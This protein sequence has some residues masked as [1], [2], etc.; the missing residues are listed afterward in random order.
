MNAAANSDTIDLRV[1]FNKVK[2]NWYWFMIC[3]MVFGAL[4][5][6]YIKTTPKT[7]L[8]SST[9]LLSEQSKGFGAQRDEFL[10][11]QALLRGSSAIEDMIAILTSSKNITNALRALDF[12]VT[13]HETKNFLEVE[14]FDY[15]P[16]YVK[17]DSATLQAAAVPIK[18]KIDTANNTYE[19]N[20]EAE[21][22]SLY[23][24]RTQQMT[25]EFVLDFKVN[26]GPIKIGEPFKSPNLSFSIEFPEDRTYDSETE[27]HFIIHSLEGQARYFRGKLGV[28]PLSD[29]SNIVVLTTSGSIVTKEKAFIDKVMETYI[30]SESQKRKE[31]GLKTIGYIDELIGVAKDSLKEDEKAVREAITAG[32]SVFDAEA[33]SSFKMSEISRLQD[34]RAK[35]NAKLRYLKM[36]QS[37][38]NSSDDIINIAAPRSSGID[39]PG[40]N[41]QV[42]E[43]TKLNADLASKDGGLLNNPQV[44]A[45]KKRRRSL[46]QALSGT[47]SGLIQSTEFVIEDLSKR[48][49]SNQYQLNSLPKTFGQLEGVTREAKLSEDLYTY[50]QEKRAEAGIAIASDQVDK[51]VVDNAARVS[52]KP[53]SPDKKM[54]LGGALLL[55]LALPLGVILLRDLFDDTVGDLDELKRVSTVPVLTTIPNSKRKRITPDEPKSVLAEA[56]RT[57]R[58][59]LQYLNAK[60][61]TNIIG[62][63]SSTSGEGKSFCA[64]NL[65]TIM[66]MSGKRTVLVDCDMRRPR[67]L[68]YMKMTSE[69]GLSTYLIDECSIDDLTRS[70]DI[71][72]LDVIGAGPI[73]PNPLE[74]MES[75]RL[76]QLLDNLKDRYDRIVLDASPMGLVSEFVILMQH[77]D[78]TLYVVRENVTKKGMLDLLNENYQNEK[79]RNVNL[80][81]NDVKGAG[82]SGDQY[83]YYTK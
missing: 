11:G 24:I 83:G 80:I 15:P 82:A 76:K 5:V 10:K 64:I 40:L 26:S 9:M 77:L 69:A 43:L 12:G 51:A 61:N 71:A 2:S 55:G 75:P 46:R 28:E 35:E 73:P 74:L 21:N 60:V 33:A 22:V 1:I 65:A 8:V 17:V 62:L 20:A 53:I 29:E 37:E 23:N 59:N 72:G 14:K 4:A 19:V 66:A 78:V 41:S 32:E 7:Y 56:F 6:M 49:G 50:L 39:D 54:I 57:A 52:S 36:I 48:I 25:D 38:L 16:F 42:Q 58:I 45:I 27:Y 67:V 68:E 13:Y 31:K 34:E 44:L 81:L 18:I 79:V 30:E 47:V 3:S 63:T 70:S